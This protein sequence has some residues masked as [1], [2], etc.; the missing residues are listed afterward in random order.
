MAGR[1]ILARNRQDASAIWINI[2]KRFLQGPIIRVTPH[3]VHIKDPEWYDELYC[4]AREGIRN[5]YPP[6]ALMTG[7]PLGT[8]AIK[9]IEPWIHDKVDLLC[10]SMLSQQERDGHVEMRVNFLAMTTDMV[11]AHTLSGSRPQK[12]LELLNSESDA[13]GWQKTIAAVALLTPIVKQAPWL[14]PFALRLS[15][16]FWMTVAP[17]L[18]RIVLLHKSMRQIA[19]ATIYQHSIDIKKKDINIREGLESASSRHNIFHTI[20]ESSLPAEEK[21]AQ[22]L[23]QE[24]FVA[25]AAGGETCA[26]MMSNAIFYILANR[27]HVLPTLAQELEEV[28]PTLTCRPELKTLERLPYLT[29]VIRETLRLTALITSRLPLVAPDQVLRYKDFIIPPG[30]PVSMSLR[31]VLHNPHIFRDPLKFYPERW[32]KSD[33]D[34]DRVNGFYVPFGRG[35]RNCLGINL[36]DIDYKRDVE[37]SRDCFIGEP[38]LDSP[39]LFVSIKKRDD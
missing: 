36:G 6:S 35:T 22:R 29:A 27:D 4:A 37:A 15:A 17:P 39:G 16:S 31:H 38:R 20:L 21:T 11:A 19:Q 32:L 23:G 2:S 3:E 25:I 13:R 28:M 12:V 10:K 33:P 7:T 24:G 8:R 9:D 26:R 18:G 1:P 34:F 5:K 30:H 14:I